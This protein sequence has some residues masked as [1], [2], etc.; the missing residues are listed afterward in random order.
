[1]ANALIAHNRD[2]DPRELTP[3]ATK[4]EGQVGILQF[5]DVPHEARRIAAVVDHLINKLGYHPGEILI[6]A[7]RRTI[8]NPIHDELRA[9][10]IPSKSYYQESE[11]DSDVAQ[12]RVA[13]LKLFV[14][15]TDRVALRWLVGLGSSDFRTGAYSRVRAY[16][17]ETG[18]SPWDALA[19]L[20]DGTLKLPYCQQLVARFRAINN[21]LRF[22]E[23]H[24]DISNFV[25]RWLRA[26]FV[27][28]GELRLLV[29]RLVA[30]AE[31]PEDLLSL[32]IEEISQPEIPPDVTEVRIMSLHKSK[33]LSSPT[34]VIAGCVEG[35]LPAE[36]EDATPVD[37][38]AILEEQRRLFYVG[39]TRVKADPT[40]NRP[41][42]LLMTGSR[43]MSLADAMSSNIKPA[44]QRFGVVDVHLSRFITELGPTAPAPKAS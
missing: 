6:L 1:M 22:L 9:R 21:E 12:E 17:E 16:C 30:Q 8:G 39:V 32:M 2:R 14:N 15:R 38:E 23:E 29:A 20:A 26:E 33:G 7:Q 28:A 5:A 24:G 35:L 40:S 19:K 41:G 10:G 44:R 11:L 34:V 25:D 13:M 37:R 42:M 43:T 3:I 36:P 4:G 31:A 18:D 27:G